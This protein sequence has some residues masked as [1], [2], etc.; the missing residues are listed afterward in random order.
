MLKAPDARTCEPA[1][2]AVRFFREL[3]SIVTA[4]SLS[5]ALWYRRPKEANAPA[6]RSNCE[7]SA[8]VVAP[9][10]RNDFVYPPSIVS[11]PFLAAEINLN[12]NYSRFALPM[13][14]RT[15]G[16]EKREKRETNASINSVQSSRKS[17]CL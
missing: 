10:D 9:R 6:S 3:A 2:I 7:S 16:R 15:I 8:Y 13:K 12:P 5:F 14:I 4:L 17:N 11:L 1:T